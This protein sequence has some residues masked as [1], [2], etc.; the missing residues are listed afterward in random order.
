MIDFSGE[1]KRAQ[2]TRRPPKDAEHWSKKSARYDS[3]D[4]KNLYAEEFLRRA[5]IHPGES[6]FDMGCG[7]GSLAVPLALSGHQVWAADFSEGMLSKL[8][9]NMVM[10]QASSITPL[11]MSWEDDWET[12]GI[13]ENMVDIAIASRSIAVDDLEA[14]LNKLTWVARRRCCISI[15]TGT[16]PTIDPSLLRQIDVPVSPTHDF[17]YA[18]GI[19]AQQG[20]EPTVDYIHSTR[21][22][23]FNT[24]EE[25]L[26]DFSR[27]IDLSNPSMPAPERA[28]AIE[29]LSQWLAAHIVNNPD[30]GK[31]NKKGL[32][33][34]R[35]CLDQLRIVSWAF[36]AWNVPKAQENDKGLA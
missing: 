2:L 5:E 28:A 12:F 24:H 9:E 18:F 30:A 33:E 16:S 14:A 23:T 34:G 6:V 21:K 25:A 27:M 13:T 32:P 29:R 31:P 17:V 11:L 22:D 10:R 15:P 19:L 20:L 35:L 26:E 3:K 36:I 7:T 8:S 4:V 1:W